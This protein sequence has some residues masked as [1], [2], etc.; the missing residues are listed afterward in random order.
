VNHLDNRAQANRAVAGVAE[1]MRGQQQECRP[2]ALAAARPQILR[3]FRDGAD[4]GSGIAAQL[5]LDCYEIV[6]QQLENLFCRRY[7]QCAQNSP[8]LVLYRTMLLL[9]PL[10]DGRNPQVYCLYTNA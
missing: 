3:N 5:L 10:G 6:S 7:C 1:R 2:D 4:A 8:G 9:L